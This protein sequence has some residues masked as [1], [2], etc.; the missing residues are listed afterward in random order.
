MLVLSTSGAHLLWGSLT[1]QSTCVFVVFL[2]ISSGWSKLEI[3]DNTAGLQEYSS[4]C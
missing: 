1:S 4:G 3:K 2:F